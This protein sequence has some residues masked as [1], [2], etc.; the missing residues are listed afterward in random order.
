MRSEDHQGIELP[1]PYWLCVACRRRTQPNCTVLEPGVTHKDV[2][3]RA[4]EAVVDD[5]LLQVSPDASVGLGRKTED[6]EEPKPRGSRG[7]LGMIS[8]HPGG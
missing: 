1:L 7:K 8:H 4:L 5:L 2:K 6:G 3:E